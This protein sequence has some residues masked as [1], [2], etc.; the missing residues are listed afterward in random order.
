MSK[1]EASLAGGPI[2]ERPTAAIQ[3]PVVASRAESPWIVAIAVILA[4]FMDI[5]DTAIAS[6]ALP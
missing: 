1:Q 2:A 5:L 4:T 3:S 6:V